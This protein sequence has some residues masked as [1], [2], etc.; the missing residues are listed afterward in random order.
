M[1]F[2][3]K[4]DLANLPSFS[5][6]KSHLAIVKR[7]ALR[8]SNIFFKKLILEPFSASGQISKKRIFFILIG[9]KI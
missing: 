4:I 7:K 9:L 6:N 1:S 8:G 3:E 2:V 5:K